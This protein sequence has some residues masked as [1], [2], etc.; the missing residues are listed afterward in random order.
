MD[1]VSDNKRFPDPQRQS[2]QTGS[3]VSGG[4]KGLCHIPF[5]SEITERLQ[6]R[7]GAIGYAP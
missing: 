5:W 3:S 2:E 4:S 7:S 1:A 6:I